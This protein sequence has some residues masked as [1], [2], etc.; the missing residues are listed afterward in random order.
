MPTHQYSASLTIDAPRPVVWAIL[1]DVGNWPAWTPTMSR[2]VH[3]SGSGVG[4]EYE[5]KQPGLPATTY[6]I[7]SWA[8]GVS[9]AW[10]SSG[11][12]NRTT[13]DHVL[14]EMEQGG[15]RV[16]L[17]IK[18][19]GWSS[20]LVWPLVRRKVQEFVDLEAASLKARAETDR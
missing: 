15:T 8:D 13:A 20:G 18:M 12:G 19:S 14:E 10:S 16:T 1:R 2:V 7:D 17:T 6:V 11:A 5:V 9:F 3:V 4:A